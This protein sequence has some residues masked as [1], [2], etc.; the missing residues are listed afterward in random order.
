MYTNCRV[1]ALTIICIQSVEYA[2]AIIV[3]KVWSVRINNMYTKCRV[4]AST[5]ICIQ[6]LECTH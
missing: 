5:I 6:R 4:Y 2:T 3:Y 1:Y